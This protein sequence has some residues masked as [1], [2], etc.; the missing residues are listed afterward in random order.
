MGGV[1][2]CPEIVIDDKVKEKFDVFLA[3]TCIFELKREGSAE[4]FLLEAEEEVRREFSLEK[5]KDYP[6][7][8]A[9]RDFYWRLGIDPTKQ[10][11]SSEALVR[12]VLR[13]RKVPRI[14]CIVDVGN[15]VS[16]VTMVPIGI[17]DLDK[18]HP[19]LR[20]RFAEE[21]E[22][23]K[24]IGGSLEKLSREQ[25]VLADLWRVVHVFPH[26]DCD[27]TKVTGETRNVLVVACGVPGLGEKIVVEATREVSSKLI[28][29]CGGQ[30]TPVK[31]IK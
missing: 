27:E 25:I 15:A 13:G 31:I 21:G 14:N 20:L 3:V 18:L 11:P 19:P 4:K 9:L 23:F 17:Y 16:M 24:P 30:S 12:R 29:L 5:L 10:R 6:R 28:E 2:E 22:M 7:V 1:V 26:R 8:R